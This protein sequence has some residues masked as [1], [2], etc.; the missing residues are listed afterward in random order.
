MQQ[1]DTF[2]ASVLEINLSIYLHAVGCMSGFYMQIHDLIQGIVEV[3]CLVSHE[4]QQH[5]FYHS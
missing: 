5:F 2:A 4:L 1:F 3:D